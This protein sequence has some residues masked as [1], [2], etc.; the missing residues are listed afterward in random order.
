MPERVVLEG[1]LVRLEPL[2]AARH[3][4]PQWTA[5]RS[6]D[7]DGALWTYLAYGPFAS[8]EAYRE[9]LTKQEA[10]VDPLFFTVVPRRTGVAAGVMGLMRIT[11]EHGVIEVG[12]ICFAPG[13]RRTAEPTEAMLLLGD[14]VFGRLGYRRFEWK[15]DDGNAPSKRA[16]ERY[17]FTYEGL[18]RQHMVVKGRNRDTAWFSITDREWPA[19]RAALAA[20]VA[21]ENFDAAGQQ[22]R[23]LEEIR[24]AGA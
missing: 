15:C 4:E 5:H 20:W 7:P 23:K 19:V 9:H 2:D 17:G 22:R 8:L 24:Q 1:R 13:L 16:A 18:F 12:H 14:Y 21:P 11:P 10:S 3:A 6:G